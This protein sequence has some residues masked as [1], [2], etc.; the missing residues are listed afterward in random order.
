MGISEL[1]QV[2]D[3]IQSR[4]RIVFVGD[5]ETGKTSV[6]N[7]LRHQPYPIYHLA[8]I[9]DSHSLEE[10]P[11]ISIIDTAGAA[12]FDRLRPFSYESATDVVICFSVDSQ[13]SFEQVL[14]KW[15]PEVRF[16]C[17]NCPI[18][19]LATK[20]DLR[21]DS[22]VAG[23]LANLGLS[24]ITS[25]QGSQL[26]TV[27]NAHG[28]Y[29]CSAKLD[30]NIHSF[31]ESII[32]HVPHKVERISFTPRARDT[33]ADSMRSVLSI[34][35]SMSSSSSILTS[36]TALCSAIRSGLGDSISDL[37]LASPLS[38]KM[39]GL[40]SRT[41]VDS[42]TDFTMDDINDL[43]ND[44]DSPAALSVRS[45]PTPDAW[46]PNTTITPPKPI[47]NRLVI[48]EAERSSE[49]AGVASPA[50]SLSDLL[51][52][53]QQMM[54]NS[55][56]LN[57]ITEDEGDE[58]CAMMV[59]AIDMLQSVR[60]PESQYAPSKRLDNYHQKSNSLTSSRVSSGSTVVSVKLGVPGSPLPPPPPSKNEPI[61]QRKRSAGITRLD[62][63]FLEDDV[64]NL[65]EGHSSSRLAPPRSAM[66]M[67]SKGAV[68][69]NMS[70]V[71][72]ER[73]ERTGP[74]LPLSAV[75][76]DRRASISHTDSRHHR[77]YNNASKRSSG[78]N[79]FFGKR[80]FEHSTYGSDTHHPSSSE[81]GNAYPYHHYSQHG[82]H[83]ASA[84]KRSTLWSL[85]LGKK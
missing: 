7:I 85:L 20:S 56:S 58:E 27:I 12:A 75:V 83:H 10:F 26:A 30:I 18:S 52:E 9:E 16:F 51:M 15:V 6:I 23:Q 77:G 54:L 79:R 46:D 60:A 69:S 25:D 22:V 47:Y 44:T 29:E 61:S 62:L 14:E 8:T 11:N 64:F 37:N 32:A 31:F 19:L 2:R 65:K 40:P 3:R 55:A 59:E 73:E 5:E 49:F 66:P 38:A 42:G 71:G 81:H 53:S 39:P 57:T 82:L 28:Y 78:W 50:V 33:D 35:S 72:E 76:L 74:T 48:G 68:L 41:P 84:A 43:G 1:A 21:S 34:S 36:D 24:P 13:Q 67:P 17:A 45:E 70:V 63:D 4:R 80:R